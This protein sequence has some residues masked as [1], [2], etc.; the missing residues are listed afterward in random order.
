MPIT[1]EDTETRTVGI[2]IGRTK[3]EADVVE[4]MDSLEEYIRDH[5]TR[6]TSTHAS[7]LFLFEAMGITCV[8]IAG[9]LKAALDMLADK[10]YLNSFQVGYEEALESE[11]MFP[12]LGNANEPFDLQDT[13]IR[14]IDFS[15]IA[16][17]GEQLEFNANGWIHLWA[18]SSH[19]DAPPFRDMIAVL[20]DDFSVDSAWSFRFRDSEGFPKKI[21]PKVAKN[22]AHRRIWSLINEHC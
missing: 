21:D 8:V 22:Q 19:N 4:P 17:M 20:N 2:S 6:H 3:E 14:E 16:Y 7:N 13:H 12:R 15:N 18:N 10:G 1:T 9:H 11:E 5:I